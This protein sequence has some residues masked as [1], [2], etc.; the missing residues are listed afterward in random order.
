MER[1]EP[2]SLHSPDPLRD[3]VSVD[4]A[5]DEDTVV[6]LEARSAM[7]GAS[8]IMSSAGGGLRLLSPPNSQGGERL[9]PMG[10]R[11]AEPGSEIGDWGGGGSGRLFETEVV[12][13]V[14]GCSTADQ[15]PWGYALWGG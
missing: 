10:L 1:L 14:G 9:E 6:T 8:A 15:H 2:P 4:D 12:V 5:V 11:V 3:G 13:G 7:G